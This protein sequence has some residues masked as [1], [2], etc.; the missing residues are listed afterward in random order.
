MCVCVLQV[1]LPQEI[2]ELPDSRLAPA[3]SAGARVMFVS[4]VGEHPQPASVMLLKT[5][6]WWVH[7]DGA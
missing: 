3:V 4:A 7:L 1:A 2:Q 5:D 6:A